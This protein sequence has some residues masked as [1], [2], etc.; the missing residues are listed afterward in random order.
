MFENYLVYIQL[1]HQLCNIFN[2]IS[3]YVLTFF[4]VYDIIMT[5]KEKQTNKKSKK[6]E[7]R[8]KEILSYPQENFYKCQLIKI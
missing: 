1:E 5:T 4:V 2:F 6:R 7:V 8:S 3:K